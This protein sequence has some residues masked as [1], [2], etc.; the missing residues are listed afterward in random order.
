MPLLGSLPSNLLQPYNAQ[1]M[2]QARIGKSLRNQGRGKERNRAGLDW[3][4]GSKTGIIEN[5]VKG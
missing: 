4:K 3:D 5:E 2:T 1:R